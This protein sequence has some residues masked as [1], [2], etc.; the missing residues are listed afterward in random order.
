MQETTVTQAALKTLIITKREHEIIQFVQRFRFVT[1][2]DIKKV[3]FTY[4]SQ[5]KYAGTIL[6]NL[7]GKQDYQEWAY[8]YRFPML[9]AGIGNTPRIYT[10]GEMGY[11]Y[12][13]SLGIKVDWRYQP[14]TEEKMPSYGYLQHPL[15][16]TSVITDAIHYVRNTPTLLLPVI[17]LDYELKREARRIPVTL[18]TTNGGTKTFQ[19]PIEPDAW[20]DF[21]DITQEK[22]AIWKPVLLEIDCDTEEEDHLKEHI[23]SRI[24]FI[25]PGGL[26]KQMFNTQTVTVAYLTTGKQ[27]RLENMLHITEN[28]LNKLNK[29]H[30]ARF[31]RFCRLDHDALEGVL[32]FR[33]AIWYQPYRKRPISLLG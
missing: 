9:H 32:L 13:R 18:T 1:L 8:L 33:D 3:Y 5:S 28:L 4:P 17:K 30:L 14:S 15:A 10:L 29:K 12:Q 7:A 27:T 6:A 21:K 20:L 26:Y 19:Y 25:Q 23:A 2:A 16:L 31:F 11:A 24:T 22:H